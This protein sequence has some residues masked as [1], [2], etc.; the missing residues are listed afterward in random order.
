MEKQYLRFYILSV[1]VIL[2]GAAYPL[3]MGGLTL[4]A[5]IKQGYVAAVDYPKYIIPYTPISIAL[6]SVVLLM[7]TIYRLFKRRT[8][9][10]ASI[11]GT[12]VFALTELGFERI[13]VAQ[14]PTSLKLPLESWQYSLC[15]ATPEV[16]KSIGQPLYAE[17]NPAFKLHFYLIALVIILAVINVIL[18]FTKMIKEQ[19]FTRK[20]P[21]IA[22][23]V[24]VSVFLGLCILACFT[25]FYRNGTLNIS[26]LSAVLMSIFFIVFGVT[27][28][29]YLGCIFYGRKRILSITVPSLAASATTLMMYIGELILMDGKLFC[30]GPGAIFQPIGGIPFAVIDFILIILSGI[31]TYLV[32]WFLNCKGKIV[33]PLILILICITSGVSCI[34]SPRIQNHSTRVQNQLAKKLYLNEANLSI[35]NKSISDIGI[36]MSVAASHV[37]KNTAVVMLAFSKDSEEPFGNCL[38]PD[39][40]EFTIENKTIEKYMLISELSEDKKNLYCYLTWHMKEPLDGKTVVLDVEQLV[41]NESQVE[42][43]TFS[44]EIINGKWPLDFVLES[45]K[46]NSIAVINPNLSERVSMCG[47]ELQINSVVIADLQVIVNT[48]TLSDKGKPRDLLSSV[49]TESGSY[50][51]VYVTVVYED[52]SQSKKM[53]CHL[54]EDNNIIAYSFNTLLGKKI[55]KVHVKGIVILI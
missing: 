16:L 36:T 37:T 55:K 25:A 52:G 33:I 1:L 48:T 51:G 54:D 39:L 3:Y 6:I 28:G 12:A 29:T 42:G 19:D 26:P 45:N 32:L 50:Y 22:Q 27:V 44:D 18:G 47:K 14:G 20:R 40:K 30:F 13:H 49:S 43:K 7:P 24:C 8:L 9:L 17:N 38:N 23:F 4:A 15:V 31:I 53:D 5:Y 35:E 21:L 34:F 41:C 11:L 10:A 46:N 2:L